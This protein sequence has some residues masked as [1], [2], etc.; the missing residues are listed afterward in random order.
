MRKDMDEGEYTGLCGDSIYHE[1]VFD[2]IELFIFEDKSVMI[3]DR[4]EWVDM[5]KEEAINVATSIL[6]ELQR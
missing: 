3:M 5:S 4:Y 6:R 1:I 2:D